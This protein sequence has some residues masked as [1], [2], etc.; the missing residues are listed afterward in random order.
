M[1]FYVIP[2][3]FTFFGPLRKKTAHGHTPGRSLPW[4]TSCQ[5]HRQHMIPSL[6]HVQHPGRW[7]HVRK[8]T[9]IAFGRGWDEYL[10]YSILGLMQSQINA[11]IDRGYIDFRYMLWDPTSIHI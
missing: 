1:V 2:M 7:S 11:N 3:F 8:R 5:R 6:V 9:S 10:I 4:R